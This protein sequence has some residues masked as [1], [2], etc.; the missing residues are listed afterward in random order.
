[1]GPGLLS[2]IPIAGPIL[3][4]CWITFALSVGGATRLK[5]SGKGA[6]I[7]SFVVMGAMVGV[8]IAVWFIAG[9][10]PPYTTIKEPPLRSGRR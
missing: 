8:C 2:I 9:Y 10:I 7:A 4:V 5:I 6:V 3:A 1:M